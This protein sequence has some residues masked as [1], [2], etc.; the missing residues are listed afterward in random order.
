MKPLFVCAI[1]LTATLAF[2][3]DPAAA[4]A[5]CP[6]AAPVASNEQRTGVVA[7]GTSHWYSHQTVGPA[8]TRLAPVSGT[9]VDLYV[10]DST[11]Q[12]LLCSSSLGGSSVDQC[13]VSGGANYKVEVRHWS[14]AG[15]YTIRFSG[16]SGAIVDPDTD[17]DGIPDVAEAALCGPAA[18]RQLVNDNLRSVG[19]CATPADFVG[20]PDHVKRATV[21]KGVVRG[22]DADNDGFPA[23]VTVERQEIVFNPWTKEKV[24]VN[25]APSE[26]HAVDTQDN[27]AN[28]PVLSTITI[29]P[30]QTGATVGGD[31]DQDFLPSGVTVTRESITFDRRDPLHPTRAPGGS[32]FLA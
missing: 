3:A 17:G 8:T 18:V 4:Y 6:A 27:D 16:A 28:F 11:C 20:N 2:A 19:T 7:P 13:S 26:V 30:L 5:A 10:W 12:L 15:G 21:P 22:P 31:A 24:F 1:L 32:D 14:G 29:G 25:V 23:Y 9:D